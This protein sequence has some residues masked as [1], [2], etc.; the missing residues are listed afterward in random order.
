M[1]FTQ[2]P[3]KSS[4]CEHSAAIASRGALN[5]PSASLET[6]SG[7]LHQTF[8]LL[9]Q[10][11][12][13][14]EPFLKA[15]GLTPEELLQKLPYDQAR[16]RGGEREG[17]DP[18]RY[19]DGKQVYQTAG[20]LYEG[21][22]GR[23]HVT[24]LGVATL[25]WLPRLNDKNKVILGRHA[26]YALAA[27]QLRNPTGAGERYDD[28]F[29]VFPFAFIWRAMLSLDGR[30]SSDEINRRLFKVRNETELQEAVF[31]IA[32]SRRTGDLTSLGEEVLTGKGKNDRIIP[33]MSI[34][35]FGWTL[36]PDKRSGGDSSYYELDPSMSSVL[37]EASRV[38]HK[39]RIFSTPQ[40][41]VQHIASCASLPK[42]LR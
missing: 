31:D 16:S 10:P 18:K 35:S 9:P 41:Y 11:S 37:M 15:E 7:S 23:V 17:P 6:W 12:A 8:R 29:E 26:A 25:R 21:A 39:H 2:T 4:S 40:D 13:H 1:V 30:I 38:R 32:E 5:M 33:W 27:C 42:D 36:F 14:L 24:L 28:T 20:L 34:A 3:F 22:D 19:R